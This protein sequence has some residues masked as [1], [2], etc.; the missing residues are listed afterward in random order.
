MVK[1]VLLMITVL[2]A[3]AL[4]PVGV[5]GMQQETW[6]KTTAVPDLPFCAL[7]LRVFDDEHYPRVRVYILMEP[8][9]VTE[10][11][12]KILFGRVGELHRSSS[13]LEAFAYTDVEQLGFLAT[14]QAHSG[15][16]NFKRKESQL[17]YYRRD[18]QVELFRYN[19]NHPKSGLRTVIIRGKE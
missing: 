3:G 14:R 2:L 8:D 13:S 4:H 17:A 9:K 5:A 18:D 10:D 19:P 15:S 6:D 11:N 16:P 7:V 1:I 12:L